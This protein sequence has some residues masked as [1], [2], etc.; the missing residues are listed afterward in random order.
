LS[1]IDV[2]AGN[3]KKEVLEADDLVVVEFWHQRCPWCLR[4][5]PIYEELS[6]EYEGGVK[7]T[8]L[9][10]LESE[11]NKQI[12]TGNGVM[13][14]PSLVFYCGGR[15]IGGYA[16]FQPKEGLK[17]VVDGMAAKQRD[18]LEQSTDLVNYV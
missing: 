2:D 5:A 18:C 1:V 6:G 13:G 17:S 12:A 15:S 7:F 16:G 11:E 8:R 4:L 3:W 10:I 14:T 9:N